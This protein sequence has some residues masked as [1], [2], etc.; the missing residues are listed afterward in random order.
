MNT[1]LEALL[2]RLESA[3]RWERTHDAELWWEVDRPAASRPYWAAC[4]GLPAVT[5]ERMGD[6]LGKLAVIQSAPRYGTDLNAGLPGEWIVE[7]AFNADPIEWQA[8]HWIR[9]PHPPLTRNQRSVWG[10]CRGVIGPA[11]MCRAMRAARLRAIIQED[12]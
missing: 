8:V 11:G 5:P 3:D 7:A 1:E 10:H 12:K 4:M 2:R 6:W 9:S